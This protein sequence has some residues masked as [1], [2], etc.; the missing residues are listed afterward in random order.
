MRHLGLLASTIMA[1]A[2]L[3]A[4]VD[5]G[6]LQSI[7]HVSKRAL[8]KAGVALKALRNADVVLGSPR[9]KYECEASEARETAIWFVESTKGTC[10]CIRDL[11]SE[12]ARAGI[13]SHIV[14]VLFPPIAQISI[15]PTAPRTLGLRHFSSSTQIRM[16][17]S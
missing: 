15:A 12:C 16:A 2:M 13:T 6:F 1:M 10:G 9:L 8:R 14:P 11:D 17:S 4:F 3:L 5:L 7:G